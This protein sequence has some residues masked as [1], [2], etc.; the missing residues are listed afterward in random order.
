MNTITIT[1]NI[2][3]DCESRNTQSGSCI[4]KFTLA[5]NRTYKVGEDKREESCFID[6]KLFGKYAE[7]MAPQLKKGGKVVV[8]GR[9]AQESWEDKNTKTKRSKH[10]I[11]VESVELLASR[12]A[13]GSPSPAP[14]NKPTVTNAH[15]Q[16]A[17]INPPDSDDV[18]F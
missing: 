1:G 9:L 12:P 18:P 11:A 14:V 5:N 6:C 8:I 10:V 16:P 13:T 17:L 15:G 2:V 7:M 4:S 3:A